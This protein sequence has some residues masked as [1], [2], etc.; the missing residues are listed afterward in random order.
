MTKRQ[1]VTGSGLVCI[2]ICNYDKL[3]HHNMKVTTKHS[4][5]I[6]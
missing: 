6:L 1:Y 3:L 2:K 5:V 4:T